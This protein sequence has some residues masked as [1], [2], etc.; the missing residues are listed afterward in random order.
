MAQLEIHTVNVGQGDAA[1]L[2]F[3]DDSGNIAQLILVDAG[4]AKSQNKTATST[5]AVTY[6]VDN[7]FTI[8]KQVD[9]V[10][11]SHWDEDHYGGLSECYP[12]MFVKDCPLISPS[13]SRDAHEEDYK[14]DFKFTKTEEWKLPYKSYCLE[15]IDLICYASNKNQLVPFSPNNNINDLSII[16]T[17]TN[18]SSLV[19]LVTFKRNERD[20]F[21]YY[22]GGDISQAIEKKI[23]ERLPTLEDTHFYLSSMKVSHHGSTTSTP[24]FF[25]KR[26]DR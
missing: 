9:Q 22:T 4:S 25:W 10:I 5:T 14:H 1:F 12:T 20:I 2:V 26:L 13:E 8:G 6:W 19:F 16:T 24:D 3:K 17:P 18:V 23:V 15:G 21:R 11:I 7:F